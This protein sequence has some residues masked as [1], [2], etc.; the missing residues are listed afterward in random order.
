M[1]RVSPVLNTFSPPS[2]LPQRVARKT[3]TYAINS[4]Q[5]MLRANKVRY[6]TNS[7]LSQIERL[8]SENFVLVLNADIV[9]H[10][11]KHTLSANERNRGSSQRLM[12]THPHD[13]HI[14]TQ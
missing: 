9:I 8:S 5:I 12:M 6:A 13:T 4:S 11:C 1:P 3:T 2:S 7:S 14:K 10:N